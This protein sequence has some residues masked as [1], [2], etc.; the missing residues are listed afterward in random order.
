MN[1]SVPVSNVPAFLKNHTGIVATA[2]SHGSD[3]P[4]DYFGIFINAWRAKPRLY[5]GGKALNMLAVASFVE[6]MVLLYH[7]HS[8]AISK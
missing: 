2:L 3:F 4:R 5:L 7:P 1:R 6:A 8:V